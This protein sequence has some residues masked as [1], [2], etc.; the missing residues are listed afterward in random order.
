MGRN[1][2]GTRGGL[3]PGDSNNKGKITGVESLVKMKDPQMYKETKAAISRFHSVLGVRE[4]NIKLATLSAGTRNLE[5]FSV[6][7]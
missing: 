5:Q 3:Q 1:S 4:K 6:W 2:S 7:S